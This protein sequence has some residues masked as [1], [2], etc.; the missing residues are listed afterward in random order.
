MAEFVENGSELVTSDVQSD[1]FA[2]GRLFMKN[3]VLICD[4]EA[5]AQWSVACFDPDG[6]R[7]A[8]DSG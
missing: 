8:D 4:E 2:V 3:R 7:R 1:T 5:L 6:A